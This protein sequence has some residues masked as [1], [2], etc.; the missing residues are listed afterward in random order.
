MQRLED[1]TSLETT[2][3]QSTTDGIRRPGVVA[4]GQR[5]TEDEIERRF[6]A[7]REG[8]T[9]YPMV[10]ACIR[11]LRATGWLNFRMRAMI[12]SFACYTL[13]LDWRLINP[14][15]ARQFTDYEPGIH[16][17]QL[18]MQSGST[19][20]N[21]LRIYNP[22]M[23][24]KRHDPSGAFIQQWVPELATVPTD[25]LHRLGEPDSGMLYA[26]YKLAYVSPIVDYQKANKF[27]RTT[28]ERL[29]RA[30]ESRRLR[31]RLTRDLA[32]ERIV[33]P[34]S[35]D[36]NDAHAGAL[37]SGPRGLP[38]LEYNPVHPHGKA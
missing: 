30:P 38:V 36:A 15:L 9:G 10:D 6:R 37:V 32:P 14:W 3:L 33:G 16:L 29:R 34:A 28:I 17:N 24:A 27:A 21:Q 22:V 12:V 19:G 11:S 18:Q 26:L 25:V 8:Q 23:Q 13:W 31:G 1:R 4:A 2:C 35:V 5:L 20:I 7:W